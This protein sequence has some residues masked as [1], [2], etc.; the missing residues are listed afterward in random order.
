MSRN[1]LKTITIGIFNVKNEA[2]TIDCADTLS[3]I[4]PVKRSI[5]SIRFK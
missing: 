4:I 2:L 3:T 1:K 5:M